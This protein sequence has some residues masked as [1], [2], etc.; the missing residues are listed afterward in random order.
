M[1]ST[2][3]RELTMD[4]GNGGGQGFNLAHMIMA[5]IGGGIC[6]LGG[7]CCFPDLASAIGAVAAKQ[8]EPLFVSAVKA[9]LFTIATAA[10]MFVI[11]RMFGKAPQ[12]EKPGASTDPTARNEGGDHRG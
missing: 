12:K 8:P 9:N 1:A 11:N 4:N 3:N 6:V 5:V 2:K 7:L 10:V